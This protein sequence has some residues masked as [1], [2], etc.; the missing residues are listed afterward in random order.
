MDA[1]DSVRDKV[2]AIFQEWAGERANLVRGDVPARDA[3][4][5]LGQALARTHG[6]LKGDEI[7]FHLVDWNSDAAFIV[8]A[9]LFPARFTPDELEAGAEAM[10]IHMPSHVLA[11]ARLSGHDVED[12]FDEKDGA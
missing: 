4:T 9:I 7:A 12:I 6:A 1:H 5:I 11:A 3:N 2:Q 8:A 10:L